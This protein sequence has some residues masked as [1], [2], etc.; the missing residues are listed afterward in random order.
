MNQR[1][2]EILWNSPLV[3]EQLREVARSTSGL[4][5][6]STSKIKSVRIPVPS[7]EDQ[8]VLAKSADNWETYVKSA[9]TSVIRAAARSRALR[10]ALLRKA[11]SGRLVPQHPDDEPSAAVLDRIRVERAAQSKP[12]RTRA[13]KAPAARKAA[14]TAPAPEPTETPRTSTQQ[15]LPL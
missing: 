5:T 4:Y 14:A 1:Y 13:R 9:K 6:L 3:F 15:E 7:L 11:F 2:F 12:K 10:S 8:E